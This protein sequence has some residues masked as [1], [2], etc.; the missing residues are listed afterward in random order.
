MYKRRGH[1]KQETTGR[2]FAKN[3][4][5]IK[6]FLRLL[7]N[8]V[9]SLILSPVRFQHHVNDPL[10]PSFLLPPS[11]ILSSSLLPRT[12][13]PSKNKR[14]PMWRGFCNQRPVGGAKRGNSSRCFYK[15]VARLGSV[16]PG[17][18]RKRG[19]KRVGDGTRL[20]TARKSPRGHRIPTL[21]NW[22]TR[23]KGLTIETHAPR[24]SSPSKQPI[25]FSLQTR[26]LSDTSSVFVDSSEKD[27][28]LDFPPFF[29]GSCKYRKL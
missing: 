12:R 13:I 22:S 29:P 7:R 28:R 27:K 16:S 18:S 9:A 15:A 23:P 1:D 24:P 26:N 21:L 4:R 17:R 6:N 2:R 10:P 5:W 25:R 14:V 3:D 20:Q 11:L 8:R 19:K